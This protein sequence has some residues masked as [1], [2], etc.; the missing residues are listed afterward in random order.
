[1]QNG[2]GTADKITE[3]TCNHGMSRRPLKASYELRWRVK[4]LTTS[5]TG[6]Y[7][8]RTTVRVELENKSDDE[9]K[10]SV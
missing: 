4:S 10:K 6:E 3:D 1:M 7:K 5:R 8:T 9:N 2:G